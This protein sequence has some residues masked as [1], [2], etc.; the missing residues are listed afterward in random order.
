MEGEDVWRIDP[1]VRPEE[2][3]ALLRNFAAVI[4]QLLLCYTPGE[5]G[6]GLLKSCLS[7]SVHHRRIGK[8]FGQEDDLRV[9][10]VDDADQLL[11]EMNRLRVRVIDSEESHTFADPI[12]DDSDDF[13][14]ESWIVVV[15][16]DRIDILI[17]LRWILGVCDGSISALREE[18]L[19]ALHPGMIR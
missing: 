3:S 16:I 9:F 6:I 4:D 14:E 18:L 13:S 17:F 8:G 10:T 12:L 7:E 5:V 1:E 19:I 2:V 11:P 15:E